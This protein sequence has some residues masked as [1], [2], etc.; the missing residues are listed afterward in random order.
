MT[1]RFLIV[2]LGVV[3]AAA[4]PSFAIAAG[5]ALVPGDPAQTDIGDQASLQRG[6]RLFVNYCGGC[7]SMKLLRTSRIAEDLELT[8]A[9]IEQNLLFTGAKFGAPLEAAMPVKAATE[10][11]GKAPPD[12]SLTGKSRGSDW[13]YNYLRGFHLD[14]TTRIGWNNT[15]FPNSSMPNV[16]WELQGSQRAVFKPMPA[17]EHGATGHCAHGQAAVAGQC[18]V[19][20][21]TVTE[22]TLTAD[23]FDQT[24]RDIATFMQYA[25]EPAALKRTR[26]GVWVLLFLAFFTFMAWMLNTEYW[27]DVH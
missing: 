26:M 6:A 10:W 8:Q 22:G 19:K 9:Q 12:L 14:P 1:K 15:V 23:A 17:A 25:A 20:F 3:L 11:F 24:A 27:R 7:H 18:F 4:T 16:L 5:G 21:E 2:G 13:I